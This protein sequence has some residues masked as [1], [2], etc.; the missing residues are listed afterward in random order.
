MLSYRLSTTQ[1]AA[2]LIIHSLDLTRVGMH[3]KVSR[4]SLFNGPYESCSDVL[5][6]RQAFSACLPLRRASSQCRRFNGIRSLFCWQTDE[7][8]AQAGGKA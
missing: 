1:Y 3:Y 4:E 7:S 2:L 6:D 5:S 8:A